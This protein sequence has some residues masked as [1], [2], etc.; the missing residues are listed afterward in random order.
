M[1]EEIQIK[2]FISKP[3][4]DEKTLL[5]KDS[6][7]PK[8][9]IVT[10]SYN[11][12]RFLERTILSIL[13]QNYPNLELIIIDGGSTD[14]SL[15]IIKKYEKYIA[16]WVSEKDKGQSD[17]L[18]KGFMKATGDIIGWQNS[19][20]IYLPRA[21]FKIVQVFKENPNVDI[22]YG[23]RYDIDEDDKIIGRT[24]F[25]RFSRIVYLY[26]DVG[27]CLSTQTTFWK[28]ELFSKVG[29]LDV[30]LKFAMDY[31]WIMRAAFKGA[32]FY[33]LPFYLGAI[34]RHKL[35]KTEMFLG[36]SIHQKESDEVAKKY[37]RKK[38]L[39]FP[40]KIYSLLFRIT[41]YIFQ[42]EIEY[43]IKGFRRRVKNKSLLS[44]K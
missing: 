35:A 42:G 15:E 19:D 33:Y 31:E 43:V 13:N 29:L 34:R 17:G 16:Y 20:D 39:R 25:N 30:N 22:V 21:F 6:S 5:N 44:S 36:T 7:F 23:N 2:S 14:E 3:L 40:L 27:F 10:P 32:K 38:W 18:N 28:K 1:K 37:G 24:I 26:E 11:Q 4:F 12:G 9:S 8:I 41:D